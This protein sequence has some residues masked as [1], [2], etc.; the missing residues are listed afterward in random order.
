MQTVG[1]D[2]KENGAGDPHCVPTV[3]AGGLHRGRG[4]REAG[5]QGPPGEAETRRFLGPKLLTME[6]ERD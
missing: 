4:N 1:G 2:R 3:T 6:G 5:M